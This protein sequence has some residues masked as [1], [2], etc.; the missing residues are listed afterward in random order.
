MATEE[1]KYLAAIVKT[2]H[3]TLREEAR[4]YGP[5]IAWERHVSRKDVLQVRF[6]YGLNF[7]SIF[8][9]ILA[10]PRRP[11]R[12]FPACHTYLKMASVIVTILWFLEFIFFA[13][14]RIHGV[15]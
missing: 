3:A 6:S 12:F 14:C 2:T 1:H 7:G 15:S 10:I 11:F 4:N 8:R 9:S 5:E 13:E